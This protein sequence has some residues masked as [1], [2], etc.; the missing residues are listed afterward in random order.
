[1]SWSTSRSGIIFRRIPI[2]SMCDMDFEPDVH[3][4]EDTY[5]LIWLNKVQA[6]YLR[7]CWFM[8]MIGVTEMYFEARD[9][10]T[11][12][13]TQATGHGLLATLIQ[14]WLSRGINFDP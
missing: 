4:V 12:S 2:G 8:I 14:A 11:R 1:M 13:R 6:G 9:Q 3:A 5:A 10:R 7:P